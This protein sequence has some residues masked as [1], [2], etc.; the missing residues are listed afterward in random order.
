MLIYDF[1]L[2]AIVM[3]ALSHPHIYIYIYIYI[4]VY[5]YIS[6]YIFT[7]RCEGDLETCVIIIIICYYVMLCEKIRIVANLCRMTLSMPLKTIC[8]ICYDIILLSLWMHTCKE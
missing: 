6:L 2:L 7:V 5:I 3:F 1:L 4:Y 8:M